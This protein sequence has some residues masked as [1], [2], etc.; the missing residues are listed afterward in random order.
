MLAPALLTPRC[1]LAEARTTSPRLAKVPGGVARVDFGPSDRTP[2]AHLNDLPLLVTRHADGWSAFVG[3]PLDWRAGSTLWVTAELG[4]AA[5][6]R[7]GIAVGNKQYATQRLTVAPGKVELSA[8]NLARHEREQVYLR[9]LLRTFSETRPANLVMAPPVPGP[10]SSSF[11][12]RRVFNGQPRSPHNG[13][14]FAAPF[15]TQVVAAAAGMVIDSGDY[16]F[17]GRLLILDHGQG[18]LS[19]YAHLS[20]VD[21]RVGETVAAGAPIGK[22]GASGRVTGPHLHFAV[23]LNAA[24]VDPALFL[25]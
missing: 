16:F 13:M 4:D 10:R 15:G 9:A 12:L 17:P 14:D 11:G 22:V 25:I 6:A 1:L 21:V 20:S 23:Y 3:I 18:W 7:F 5:L 19:L 24:A 8:A 2:R